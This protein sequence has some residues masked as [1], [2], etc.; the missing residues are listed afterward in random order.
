M[1]QRVRAEIKLLMGVEGKKNIES[2]NSDCSFDQRL[3]TEIHT[4]GGGREDFS[5]KRRSGKGGR[6]KLHTRDRQD[7]A[8]IQAKKSL[9]NTREEEGRGT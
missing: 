8:V 5:Q 1:P 7:L 2:E 9:N 3:C 6:E 4:G